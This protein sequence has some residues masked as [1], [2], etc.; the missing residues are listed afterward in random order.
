MMY[1]THCQRILDTVIQANFDE[2]Q[3]FV[4]YFWQGLPSHLSS[5][6]SSNAIINLIGI[7]DNILYKCITNVL[8]TSALQT[9][10][11]RYIV[12]IISALNA[13]FYMS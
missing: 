7:C 1:R 3:T 4:L 10:S 9:F 8:L 13:C 6:I 2:I 11:D 5:I 12:I